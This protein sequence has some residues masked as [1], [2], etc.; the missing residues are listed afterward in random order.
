MVGRVP[1][2]LSLFLFFR[3]EGRREGRRQRV[4]GRE[5]KKAEGGEQEAE[6]RGQRDDR[7]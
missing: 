3:A 2:R 6:G 7:L 5:Q 4:E 1:K